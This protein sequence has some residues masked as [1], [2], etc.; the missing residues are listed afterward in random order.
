MQH[1]NKMGCG[2][3][4]EGTDN[5]DEDDDDDD[6]DEDIDDSLY[7][8]ALG[9]RPELPSDLGGNSIALNLFGTFFGSF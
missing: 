6:F 5:D 4:D 2:G 3:A 9:T 8:A 1:I 7:R